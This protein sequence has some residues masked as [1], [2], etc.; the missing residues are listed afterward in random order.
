MGILKIMITEDV[1]SNEPNVQEI[2]LSISYKELKT[3]IEIAH[4]NKMDIVIL[5]T[6][7]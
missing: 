1:F 3:F 6:Q 5:N 4:V 2:T 7:E